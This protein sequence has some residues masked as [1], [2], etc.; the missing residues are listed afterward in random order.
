MEIT[1]PEPTTTDRDLYLD[2]GEMGSMRSDIPLAPCSS[3]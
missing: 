3:G 2:Q 1:L